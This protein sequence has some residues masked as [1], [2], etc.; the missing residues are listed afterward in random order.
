LATPSPRR[1]QK[2]D[3]ALAVTRLRVTNGAL[4]MDRDQRNKA[5]RRF[6]DLLRGIA[7]DLG[8]PE[9]LS[10]AQAQLIRRCSML[11]VQ[12]EIMEHAAIAGDPFDVEVFAQLTNVLGRSFQRLGFK[13]VPKDVATLES[14]LATA[15]REPEEPEEPETP[16]E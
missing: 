7:N 10:I 6:K 14:Y 12:C 11:C 2:A 9:Q 3:I 5:S 4:F 1:R 8:G 13:R 16:E 15:Y